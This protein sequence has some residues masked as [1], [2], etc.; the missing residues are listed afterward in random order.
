MV[1]KCEKCGEKIVNPCFCNSCVAELLKMLETAN[2]IMREHYLR[3]RQRRKDLEHTQFDWKTRKS[4]IAK[5]LSPLESCA[6]SLAEMG[7]PPKYYCLCDVQSKRCQIT[8]WKNN[9][10]Q[11]FRCSPQVIEK[12]R[13]N[14]SPESRRF[15]TCY[16]GEFLRFEIDPKTNIITDVSEFPYQF[17]SDEGEP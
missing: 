14:V 15:L 7:N 17:E 10:K 8:V 5:K 12:L 1:D 13:E 3:V 4:I 11:T 2:P 16:Y 6:K 9:R